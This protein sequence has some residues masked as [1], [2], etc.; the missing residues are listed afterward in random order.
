MAN[1]NGR[2][3]VS[4]C[5]GALHRMKYEIA[6][7]LGL[8]VRN[9]EAPFATDGY[10]VEM[11]EEWSGSMPYSLRSEQW[12]NLSSREA[13]QVGGQMTARLIRQ[14]QTQMIDL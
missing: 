3:L 9:P 7:E 6:A 12:A 4:E 5:A 14:A 1:R 8:P 2:L 13:G 10:D 11:A